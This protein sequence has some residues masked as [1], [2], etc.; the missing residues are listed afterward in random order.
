MQGVIMD[1]LYA[2]YRTNKKSNIKRE[3]QRS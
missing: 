2:L 1:I 3:N